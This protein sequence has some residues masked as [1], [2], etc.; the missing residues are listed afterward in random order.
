MENGLQLLFLNNISSLKT[1]S[2]RRAG[3]RTDI[4][5]KPS[6]GTGFRNKLCGLSGPPLQE[7]CGTESINVE[8]HPEVGKAQLLFRFRFRDLG[9]VEGQVS[10]NSSSH[11]ESR[12]G[13]GRCKN[14]A[15]KAVPA[16][17][18]VA[19]SSALCSNEERRFILE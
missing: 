13:Q 16:K 14:K 2:R 9:S 12:P 4:R 19:L 8:N 1:V 15:E 7:R 6:E 5:P 18:K 11:L 3:H 10:Q 17:V